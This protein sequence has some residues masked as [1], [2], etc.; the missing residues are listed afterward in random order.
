LLLKLDPSINE[1]MM[2]PICISTGL[3]IT[4]LFLANCSDE[5]E[6]VGEYKETAI[7]YC[8]LDQSEYTH[9]IK[10]N[11]AFIGPG[12]AY[13]IAKIADSNYFENVEAVVSEYVN[14]VETRSWLLQ[15]TIINTKDTAGLFY[16][17]TQ[18]LYYFNDGSQGALNTEATYRLTIT[19]NQGLASE[20]KITGETKLVTGITSG[21]SNPSSSFSFLDS[22]G[23]LKA[24][25]LIVSNTGNAHVVNA[26]LDLEYY[27]FINNVILDSVSTHWNT[28]ESQVQPGA[29]YSTAIHGQTFYE[30]IRN[31]ATNN[32]A[33]D[34]RRLKAM[35][36]TITGGTEEFNNYINANKPSSSLAQTKPSYTNLSITKDKYVVGLFSARQT[37]TVVKAF[38]NPPFSCLDQKSRRE[39]CTGN[40]TGT[41]S[42]CSTVNLDALENYY[43]P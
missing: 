9:F 15:D 26:S 24:T 7:V 2:K 12:N 20:F 35:T 18:K 6:L 13:D 43:C 16:A 41:L 32:S 36:I 11:R 27:E 37:V 23:K 25:N 42:F 17:P 10:I 40:I 31:I 39:L 33:I 38:S 34:K 30:L 28:G 1:F 29:S 22:Q 14:E 4:L 5:I 3:L 19:I 8:L 21:Q